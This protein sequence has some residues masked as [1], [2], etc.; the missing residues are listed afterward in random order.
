[1]RVPVAE[2]PKAVVGHT[3]RQFAERIAL[4]GS[5]FLESDVERWVRDGMPHVAAMTTGMPIVLVSEENERDI[6]AWVE[7]AY[8]TRGRRKAERRASIPNEFTVGANR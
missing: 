7:S 4:N 8:P 3:V 1:M 6:F 2:V 5:R